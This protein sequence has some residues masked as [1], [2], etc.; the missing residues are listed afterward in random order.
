MITDLNQKYFTL[1][2]GTMASSFAEFLEY[3]NPALYAVYD[4]YAYSS[5][6]EDVRNKSIATCIYNIAIVIEEYLDM[7]QLKFIFSGLPAA[8]IES[9]KKYAMDVVDFFKSFKISMLDMN[10]IYKLDDRLMN[11]VKMIDNWITN[12]TFE[13]KMPF[14]YND[15]FGS[16]ETKMTKKFRYELIEKLYTSRIFYRKEPDK[17]EIKDIINGQLCSFTLSDRM[18]YNDLIA[19][20]NYIYDVYEDA[21]PKERLYA[22]SKITCIERY[23]PL[24]ML[25]KKY[26][27]G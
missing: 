2:D 7:D 27:Y 5:D 16:I 15:R 9:I 20:I 6:E 14:P 23:Q 11:K 10:I 1:E 17:Y 13:K 24:E 8:S 26:V 4:K 22:T 18:N 25:T 3:K 19:F 12:V 21:I